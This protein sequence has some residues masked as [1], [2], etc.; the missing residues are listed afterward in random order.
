LSLS[1]GLLYCSPNILRIGKSGSGFGTRH[2]F[3]YGNRSRTAGE[4]KKNGKKGKSKKAPQSGESMFIKI[5]I[6]N[7]LK[8]NKRYIN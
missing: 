8:N 6:K 3:K 1:T 4:T 2:L 7:V 5:L